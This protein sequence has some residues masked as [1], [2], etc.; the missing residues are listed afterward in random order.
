MI[1]ELPQGK[2]E[3]SENFIN[4]DNNMTLSEQAIYI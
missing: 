2:K 3:I 1:S 4:Q